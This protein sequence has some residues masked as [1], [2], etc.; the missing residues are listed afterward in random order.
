MRTDSRTRESRLTGIS[1]LLAAGLGTISYLLAVAQYWNWWIV[2]A[3][4]PLA[5]VGALIVAAFLSL[6]CEDW[7]SR[8]I[9]VLLGTFFIYVGLSEPDRL[10][11]LLMGIAFLLI[12]ITSQHAPK[13][14]D[15]GSVSLEGSGVS[16]QTGR[17]R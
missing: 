9:V 14:P 6:C 4:A 11:T 17:G 2:L 15:S 10:G 12:G 3:A 5:I 7:I 1:I 13:P 16:E 8:V